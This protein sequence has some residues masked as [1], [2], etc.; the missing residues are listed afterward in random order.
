[1]KKK[2]WTIILFSI[3]MLS[4][5]RFFEPQAEEQAIARVGSEYLYKSQLDQLTLELDSLDSVGFAKT[6]IDNWVEEKLMLQKAKLNLSEDQLDFE[7]QLNTYRNS[8]ILYAYENQLIK[9]KLDTTVH[10]EQIKQY[11]SNNKG[12]FDLKEDV[13]KAVFIK[14]LNTAPEQDSLKLWIQSSGEESSQKYKNIA[15]NFRW[16]VK[17]ILPIG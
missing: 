10:E 16:L 3:W 13:L 9:Q 17:L 14:Y 6:Y 1:M 12:N 15:P 5:C 2:A 8:L 7:E 11:Y 4:S